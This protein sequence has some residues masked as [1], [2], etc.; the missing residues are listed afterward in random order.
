MGQAEWNKLNQNRGY[1]YEYGLQGHVGS[2]SPIPDQYLTEIAIGASMT[3][4]DLIWNLVCFDT[5]N[6]I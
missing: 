6:I 2:T 5:V 4:I 3:Y 1:A